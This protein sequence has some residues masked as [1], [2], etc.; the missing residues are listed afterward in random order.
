MLR[1][2]IIGK[3]FVN[4]RKSTM[5]SE[6]NNFSHTVRIQGIGNVP[7][8]IDSVDRELSLALSDTSR[9]SRCMVYGRQMIFHMDGVLA[10]VLKD[11]KIFLLQNDHEHLVKNNNLVLGL[12][13]GSIPH[14]QTDVG[15]L[16]KKYRNKDD[17][18]LY[19]LLTKETTMYGYIWSIVTY[20]AQQ[21]GKFLGKM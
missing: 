8:V 6:R 11:L 15:T 13:D 5:L 17:K 16:Y 1:S 19:L 4:Y 2:S 18:I 14:L 20:L 21:V 12:E 9:R 10:D 3:E 7:I